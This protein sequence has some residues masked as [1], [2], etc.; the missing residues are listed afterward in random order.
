MDW[1]INGFLDGLAQ[2]TWVEAV[3]F[4]FGVV[5]VWYEKQE[6]ILVFPTGLVNVSLSIYICFK[7]LLYADMGIN[8]YYFFMSIYGWYNWSRKQNGD[9]LHITSCNIGDHLKNLILTTGS[10]IV[11]FLGLSNFT[12]SDV[13]L[14]DA[15]TT[16]LFI[17]AMWLVAR[18]KIE[19]WHFWIV[20]N[21]ISIPLYFSKGLILFSLQYFIFLVLAILGLL[22]WRA[23]LN[24]AVSSSV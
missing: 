23:K 21:L 13:P 12:N 19:N 7:A 20:G 2:M 5:S 8:T 22:S 1:V 14:W 6:N 24:T 9:A 11:L 18:K 17:T 16:S 15:L 4:A 10:F 3:A